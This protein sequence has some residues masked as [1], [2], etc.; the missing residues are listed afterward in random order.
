MNMWKELDPKGKF[1]SIYNRYSHVMLNITTE[2]THFV[3]NGQDAF[4][5]YLNTKD[6]P[7]TE[8]KYILSVGN[9]EQYNTK[10]KQV[11]V[12]PKD[13]LYVYQVVN[14]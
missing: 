13:N 3:L 4:N 5:L 7:K 1:G 2:E 14:Y 6:L 10:L 12:E 8:I 9:L 11:Y